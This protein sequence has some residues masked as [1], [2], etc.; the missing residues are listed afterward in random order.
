MTAPPDGPEEPVSVRRR[1]VDLLHGYGTRFWR[2]YWRVSVAWLATAVLLVGVISQLL[3]AQPPKSVS[4]SEASS[5]VVVGVPGLRWSD[6]D[7]DETPHLWRLAEQ[8]SLGSL[9]VD[10]APA[11]SCPLDGWLTL[12]AGAPASGNVSLHGQRCPDVSDSAITRSPD[13]DSASVDD[14]EYLVRHNHNDF[15]GVSVGTLPSAVRCT[16][17]I[18]P[19]ASYAAARQTGKLDHYEAELP[20]TS[21][22]WRGAFEECPLTI[23]DLGALPQDDRERDTAVARADAAV[24][25]IDAAL[26]DDALLLIA[27]ISDTSS[28]PQLHAVI[29]VGGGFQTGWLTSTGSQRHDNIRLIDLAPTVVAAMGRPLPRPMVGDP[30]STLDRPESTTSAAQQLSDT[31]AKASAQVDISARLVWFVT[32]LSLAFFACAAVVLLRMRRG[33]GRARRRTSSR[34]VIRALVL[35]GTALALFFVSTMAIDVV[36]WWR[37]SHP[38]VASFGLCALTVVMLGAI[39]LWGSRRHDPRGITFGVCL[40]GV[41]VAVWDVLNYANFRL[42]GV[43]THS[44]ISNGVSAGM[45]PLGFAIF[46]TSLLVA[47]GCIAQSVSRAYRPICFVVAGCCGVYVVGASYL[48]DDPVQ[49]IALTV[50]TCLAAGLSGGGWLTFARLTWAVFAGFGLML[51]LAVAKVSVAPDSDGAPAGSLVPDLLGGY[52]GNRVRLVLESDVV[53]IMNSPLT[54]LLGAAVV[55]TWLV[56]LRPAGGLNRAF[57]LYPSVRAGFISA[58]VTVALSG[59]LSGNGFVTAGAALS[60]MMPLAVIMSLRALSRDRHKGHFR[61]G[62][63]AK[64]MR[65]SLV[66]PWNPVDVRHTSAPTTGDGIGQ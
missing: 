23:V 66:L 64:S 53:S 58:A 4:R 18:G 27:G 8:G 20:E 51:V 16:T 32:V 21:T 11:V 29:A 25:D 47:T 54:L 59:M 28:T 39:V 40:I 2:S 12:S 31:A 22:T 62:A 60:V 57:G 17:A 41:A 10:T 26:D 50:G 24:A 38:V 48:G 6:I 13:G 9:S 42:G 45:R 43:V 55:L 52:G 34:W 65:R 44:P 3:P 30:L 46:A 63:G 15:Q 49:A 61:A 36:P 7:A 33:A 5:A 37:M 19:G 35:A 14:Q 56:L 1:T